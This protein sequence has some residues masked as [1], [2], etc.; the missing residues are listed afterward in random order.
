MAEG[1]AALKTK[2]AD[3]TNTC[4]TG[5]TTGEFGGGGGCL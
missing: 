1:G 5:G 4:R 3:E 2:V